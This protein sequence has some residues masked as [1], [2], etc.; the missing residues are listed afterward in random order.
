[1]TGLQYEA[2]CRYVISQLYNVPIEKIF[3]GHLAGMSNRKQKFRHQIDLYWDASDGVLE[4]KVF[5]NA[6][7]RMRPLAVEDV[8]SLI[9]V[10]RDIGAHK[11]MLIT[12]TGFDIGVIKQAKQKGIAAG[13]SAGRGFQRA[14]DDGFGGGGAGSGGDCE[15]EGAGGV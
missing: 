6:R 14:G 7:W 9:G 1:M 4:Y 5:A 10:W 15:G 2:L 12:N 3:S 8:M 13:G 11:A